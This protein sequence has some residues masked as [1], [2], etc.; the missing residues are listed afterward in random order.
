MQ[1]TF[2]KLFI[3]LISSTDKNP[4]HAGKAYKTH[5]ITIELATTV[6]LEGYD[7]LLVAATI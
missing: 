6:L 1:Q 7:E 4:P 3:L 5:E 2:K